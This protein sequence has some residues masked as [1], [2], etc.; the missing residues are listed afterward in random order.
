MDRVCFSGAQGR[1]NFDHANRICQMW[2]GS[3]MTFTNKDQMD[4]GMTVFGQNTFWVG[5]KK[6]GATGDISN[7]WKY[8]DQR[9]NGFAM[10]R[11]ASGRPAGGNC[12]T[13]ETKDGK[14]AL[15]DQNCGADFP[16]ICSKRIADTATIV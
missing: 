10:Q 12:A 4:M 1:T 9:S 13:M 2:G 6:T 11:W 16:F 7:D 15:V 8:V 14:S 5:L 3:L